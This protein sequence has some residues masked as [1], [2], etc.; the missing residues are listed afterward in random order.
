MKDF[1]IAF[2]QFDCLFISELGFLVNNI[3]DSHKLPLSLKLSNVTIWVISFTMEYLLIRNIHLPPNIYL[4]Q[5]VSGMTL[6]WQFYRVAVLWLWFKW[7]YVLGHCFLIFSFRE[8]PWKHKSDTWRWGI[9]ICENLII[10]TLKE[11]L[12]FY[13]IAFL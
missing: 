3:L 5:Y 6:D 10:T 1:Y 12:F 9:W 8:M 2:I 4:W 13:T 7:N 11:V